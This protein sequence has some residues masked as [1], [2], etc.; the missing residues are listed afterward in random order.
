MSR[1]E[2]S[3]SWIFQ[4]NCASMCIRTCCL[5]DWLSN[6]RNSR[7]TAST[8]TVSDQSMCSGVPRSSYQTE[9]PSLRPHHARP[10]ITYMGQSRIGR[11]GS[12]LKSCSSTRKC[13]KRYKVHY[14]P[15]LTISDQAN[16]LQ[17]SST[18][19]TP[20]PSP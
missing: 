12:R 9:V 13:A 4:P 15:D 6:F 7:T 5:A 18:G 14:A 1:K 10:T 3:A 20:T 2:L 11:T 16:P 19:P 8:P 17:Q